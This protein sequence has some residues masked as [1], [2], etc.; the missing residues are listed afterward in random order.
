MCLC[1]GA[2]LGHSVFVVTGMSPGRSEERGE[3]ILCSYSSCHVER[4]ERRLLL[5][6]PEGDTLRK[7]LA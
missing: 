1:H 2:A 6:C 5:S 3:R 7:G 4:A